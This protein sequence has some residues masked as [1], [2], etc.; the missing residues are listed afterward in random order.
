MLQSRGLT[1]GCCK[2]EL[3]R[4]LDERNVDDLR[5]VAELKH[6]VPAE[7]GEDVVRPCRSNVTL[8]QDPR[9]Q[10]RARDALLYDMSQL[11]HGER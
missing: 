3:R 6:W 9:R 11:V 10:L 7:C 5:R 8:V 4:Q 2:T 1:V